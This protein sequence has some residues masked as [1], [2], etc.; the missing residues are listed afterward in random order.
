MLDWDDL[1]FFLAVARNGSLT[2]AARELQV[3]QTT[4]GR[5]LVSLETSLGAQL[6][7]RTPDG[8]VLTASGEKVREQAERVEAEASAVVR[9][10]G[11][12]HGKLEGLVRVACT[13]AFAAYVIGPLL[14]DFH[15]RHPGITLELIPHVQQMS[16]AMREADIAVQFSR[17]DRHD[18]LV[19]RIGRVAYG[20]YA[21][22]GYLERFGLPEFDSGCSGHFA[23]SI[24]GDRDSDAQASWMA[25]LAA[26]AKTGLR[27]GSH[28][29]LVAAAAAGGGLACLARFQGDRKGRLRRLQTPT[30]PPKAEISMLVH[31]DM[32]ETPRIAAVLDAVSEAVRSMSHTLDPRS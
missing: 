10:I 20:L 14:G 30:S 21:S 7:Q 3:A 2:S 22:H 9:G 8:Y 5:R 31:K 32:R 23:M 6:L 17:S 25:N 18:L 26:E 27:T 12:E 19:K 13:E 24:I 1:R 16:L 28:G 15:V 29:G 4:V 11:G